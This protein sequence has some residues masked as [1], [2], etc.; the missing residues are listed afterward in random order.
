MVRELVRRVLTG[1]GYTVLEARS[2]TEATQLLRRHSGPLDLLLTDV[3]MPQMSGPEV[4][5]YLASSHP[6]T[7]VL[8]M[9]GYTDDAIVH[10]GVLQPGTNY[11]QKPFTPEAL[12]RKV[13]EILNAEEPLE[14]HEGTGA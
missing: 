3:V 4:A 12:K 14:D 5:V 9:S 11:I 7:A 8:Y 1:A 10:H 13:R 2:G 6:D